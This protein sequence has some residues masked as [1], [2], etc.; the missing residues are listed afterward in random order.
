MTARCIIGDGF[1]ID[2]CVG[3]MWYTTSHQLPTEK[4]MQPSVLPRERIFTKPREML[5]LSCTY[6]ENMISSSFTAYWAAKFPCVFDDIWGCNRITMSAYALFP[7]VIMLVDF[8][9][10]VKGGAYRSSTAVYHHIC[11]AEAQSHEYFSSNPTTLPPYSS[12]QTL[13]FAYKYT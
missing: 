2:Q 4:V 5:I 7:P 12:S 9:V 13:I 3:N 6:C 8:P 1:V 10:L 11:N